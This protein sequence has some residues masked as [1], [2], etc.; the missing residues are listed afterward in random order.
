MAVDDAC[1]FLQSGGEVAVSIDVN[2]NLAGLTCT[3]CHMQIKP[4]LF[5]GR[6]FLPF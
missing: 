3:F 2:E 5:M 6:F 1:Q 4:V